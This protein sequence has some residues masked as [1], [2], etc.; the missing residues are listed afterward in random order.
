MTKFGI[1]WRSLGGIIIL[2]AIYLTSLYNYLL[3]HTVIELCSI[4]V[5]FSIFIIAWNSRR[6]TDNHYYTFL[7]IAYL[8]V[9]ILELMHT[10]T[11][12]GMPLFLTYTSGTDT[13]LWVAARYLQSIALLIAPIFIQRRFR[14]SFTLWG[15][16]LLTVLILLTMF[17]WNIFPVAYIWGEGP[18]LFYIV[19]EFVVCSFFIMA[20]GMLWLSRKKFDR[21]VLLYLLL[22]IGVSIVAELCFMFYKDPTSPSSILGHLF[23]LISFLLIYRAIVVVHLLKPYD[24]LFYNLAQSTGLLKK[25][26]DKL[27]NI[28]DLEESIL[29]ALDAEQKVT[30]INRK[31]R[32]I[33]G[34]SET[35]ILG[36]PFDMFL[37]L[38]IRQAVK[39]DYVNIMS[40]QAELERYQERPVMTSGGEERIITW[41]NE[42]L[43]DET[44][45][46]VGTFSS[47]QDITE[48]KEAE[49][50]FRAIFSRSP[51]GMY[52]AQDGK[53]R[54]VNPQFRNY[55]GFAENELI[56]REALSL[57]LPEDATRVR[58]EAVKALKSPKDSFQTYDYRV[59]TASGKLKW[60]MESVSSIHYDG[61]QATLGTIVDVS[62]RKQNEDLFRSLS[63]IDD[64]TGLY[65]RRGFL[66]LANQQ[67]KL[68]YRMDKG[69][70][71]LFADIDKLKWINDNMGHLEGDAALINAS[72]MLKETFRESDIVGRISG[73]EF[74]VFMAGADQAYSEAIVNRLEKKLKEYNVRE[75]KPYELSLSFGIACS[76]SSEPCNLSDL[77]DTAD[78]FM[79]EN[80]REN[81]PPD[82]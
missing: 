73:D 49:D 57:V 31:G 68:S 25:E 45:K 10:L 39:N 69:V 80:K 6:Y 14:A 21:N 3:S 28:L 79:Y 81:C 66:T 9:G 4:V 38:D 24:I 30:M 52:I 26:R 15:L 59:K 67:L 61:R 50:L 64:L 23:Y 27:Q 75:K 48:R 62:E 36:R 12:E 13:Q 53:F 35:D 70:T 56:D 47:G 37:P 17:L 19:S 65:N 77:L 18:T 78:K 2:A 42:L 5:C 58:Q 76:P 46:I 51:I 1:A 11:Y 71:L 82:Q 54:L 29:L 43:R 20:A 41:H 74:A 63:L 55:L 44:G 60:F 8:Y 72:K 32:E 7:G 33:L 22:S 40:G 34:A 16:A